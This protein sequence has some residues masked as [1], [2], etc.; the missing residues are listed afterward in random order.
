MFKEFLKHVFPRVVRQGNLRITYTFCLGGL[1][2]ASFLLLIA[3]GLLLLFYYQPAPERA[4]QS[5]LMLEEA[6]WGGRYLRSLH[7]LSS[8][9]F[10]VLIFLHTLRV[11]LTGAYRK[12][13][14]LNWAIGF[15]LLCLALFAA[16]TGYLLPMDQLSLW[17]TQTGMELV[18]T[19][20]F[21]PP[22]RAILV[23]DGVG[24]PMSLLRFY[25]L[26]IV[27]LP[28]A[29]L[30]LSGLHFYRIRKDRGLL[31]YL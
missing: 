7:R 10:L 2:L 14:E 1:A 8:H 12:P 9:F 16:Y 19:M 31:P 6:V 3:S 11:I 30:C 21:G 4:F 13:R 5:I 15:S 24:E 29:I 17:A 18:N 26:H 22:V 27:L 28:L 20:F 25:I 23:P